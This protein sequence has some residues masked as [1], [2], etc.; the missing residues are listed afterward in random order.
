[1]KKVL[2][3]RDFSSS[4]DS[5]HSNEQVVAM[6]RRTRLNV[7]NLEFEPADRFHVEH[8]S[9]AQTVIITVKLHEHEFLAIGDGVGVAVKTEIEG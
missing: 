5:S 6:R 3:V 2:T 4:P 1:M 9:E 7:L 8:N